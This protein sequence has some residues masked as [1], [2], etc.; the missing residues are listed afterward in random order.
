MYHTNRPT[1]FDSKWSNR[2]FTWY[3]CI[4]LSSFNGETLDGSEIIIRFHIDDKWNTSPVG[5]GLLL[6]SMEI[7]IKRTY[8]TVDQ[9][10]ISF[11][12]GNSNRHSEDNFGFCIQYEI[13]YLIKLEDEFIG[14]HENRLQHVSG[15]HRY[16]LLY[17]GYDTVSG[18]WFKNIEVWSLLHN[19]NF[20]HIQISLKLLRITSF[21]SLWSLKTIL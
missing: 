2:H 5:K 12:I 16:H 8:E 14:F 11:Q 1:Y 21:P 19:L 6:K 20:H 15:T 3:V 9:C 10:I 17:Q 7:A 4:E 18:K 13:F